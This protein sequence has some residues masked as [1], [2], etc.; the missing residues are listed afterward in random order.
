MMIY[1]MILSSSA[2]LSKIPFLTPTDELVKDQV[3]LHM[4]GD[5]DE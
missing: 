5:A 3:H 4:G 2:S 1:V